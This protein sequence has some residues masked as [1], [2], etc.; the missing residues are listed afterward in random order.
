[1][2]VQVVTPQ[3]LPSLAPAPVWLSLQLLQL[4]KSPWIKKQH[5][6]S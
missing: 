5:L 4:L 6:P 2:L 3:V 1:M